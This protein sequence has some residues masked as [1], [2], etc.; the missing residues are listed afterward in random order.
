MSEQHAEVIAVVEGKTE[1]AFINAVLR[2][3]LAGHSV[4]M[5]ATLIGKPGQKGGVVHFDRLMRDLGA[6]LKQRPRTFVTT[7]VDYYGLKYWPGL[8]R[9]R[10]LRKS[11]PAHIAGMLN[12]AAREE[13]EREFAGQRAAERF[14]P[15][16]SMHEF[17]ALLFSDSA[18]L[19][20]HLGVDR[21]EI[22]R[23]IRQCGGAEAI[24]ND[25]NSAPSKRLQSWAR[26]RQLQPYHK[27][28]ESREIA[29]KIGIAAMRE[30]CPVFATWLGRLESLAPLQ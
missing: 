26:Q 3:H 25:S 16:I 1:R 17:E 21:R 6:H 11:A 15:Y 8:D 30:Q 23:V 2:P 12:D 18:V 24:N 5:V 9:A 27:M 29:R 7:M 10:Q 4:N 20:A 13:M 14:I 28:D 19:A 22:Q